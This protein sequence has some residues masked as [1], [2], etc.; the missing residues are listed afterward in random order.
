MRFSTVIALAGVGLGL[1]PVGAAP[2]QDGLA[3][4][5]GST[6]KVCQLT[7]DFDRM[8]GQPTLSQTGKRFG[9]FATDLG[10]SFEHDGRLFFLFGD[11]V[12]RPGDQDGIAWTR[13]RDPG[14]ISLDFLLAKDGKW[15]PPTVP[16]VDNGAFDVPSGGVD[17]GGRMFVV[18]TTDWS[19]QKGVMGRS[20]LAVSEDNGQSFKSLYD[21]STTK[22]INVSFWSSGGWLYIFGSGAYRK[23]SPYLARVRPAQLSQHSRLR[24][25]S[26]LGPSG[27]PQWDAREQVAKPIFRHDVIGEFSVA[28][29]QSVGRYVLLYNSPHPRGITLRSA[30]APWGPW[31]GGEI[32]FDPWRDGGYGRFMHIPTDF[33]A[34]RSD[35]VN[36]PGRETVW[37]GEYGPYIMA[38]FTTGGKGRC[39]L[40]YT[41]S[42]WNPYQVVVMETQL[43]NTTLPKK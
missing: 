21:L 19:Q 11:T 28:Y 18:F 23:S 41:M 9:V 34:D 16:G 5:A 15:L 40:F 3:Y 6:K 32:I 20:V 8:L 1:S 22:F 17:V 26:G 25:F 27:Q 7:G 37:G 39:R 33:K 4:V 10:S 30:L 2:N 38:R 43:T 35:S 31:S 42:T 13:S 24:Y 36:D 14:N 29:C 12:G